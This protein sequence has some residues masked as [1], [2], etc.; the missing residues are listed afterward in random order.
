MKEWKKWK[1]EEIKKEDKNFPSGLKKIRN[2][3]D[4]IYFRGNWNKE[5]FEKTLAIVGSRQ[6]TRYGREIISKFMPDFIAEKLT[7]ISGFMYGVDVEAHQKCLE[8][9]GKTIA[10]LGGGLDFLSPAENDNLYTEILKNNG[11]VISEYE[12]DFKPT[13]WSFPA[14]NRIVSALSTQGILVVEA[15]LKSGSLITA[16][17]GSEQN[18]KVFAIPGPITSRLSE[19]TNWL[20]KNN[21][22]KMVLETRDIL[23]KKII[24][25]KQMNFLEE[26][27]NT[28]E[29]KIIKLL[30]N[31]EL[32]IDELARN[33]NLK[34][35]EISTHL[36][37]LLLKD[38]IVEEAGKY[39]LQR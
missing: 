11:L 1:I 5:I 34:I 39:Y 10:V 33:L 30:Q 35:Y 28:I 20:I 32:S 8:L 2:C 22:A 3:P 23:E 15:G 37:N 25:T 4:K 21:S 31:E 24:E 29:N 27:L 12:P 14:R 13:L 26:N 36:S 9:G 17:I 18:K 38:F 7:I 19:G 16:R 6:M